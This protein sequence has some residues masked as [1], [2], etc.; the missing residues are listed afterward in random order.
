TAECSNVGSNVH[1]PPPMIAF[2]HSSCK[3]SSIWPFSSRGRSRLVRGHLYPM[4]RWSFR[5]Q[6]SL[7]CASRPAHLCHVPSAFCSTTFCA[8]FTTSPIFLDLA[9]VPFLGCHP[10]DFLHSTPR[11]PAAIMEPLD[12]ERSWPA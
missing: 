6:K 1:S 8:L 11:R 3:S 2:V 9:F 7:R 5:Q 10:L 4:A 12:K